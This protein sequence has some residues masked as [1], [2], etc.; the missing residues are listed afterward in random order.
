MAQE[1]YYILLKNKRP[2]NVGPVQQSPKHFGDAVLS[3]KYRVAHLFIDGFCN[4]AAFHDKSI[5]SWVCHESDGIFLHGTFPIFARC[6]ISIRFLN[7]IASI[8]QCCYLLGMAA[9]V[10]REHLHE[11]PVGYVL[12]ELLKHL[13]LLTKAVHKDVNNIFMVFFGFKIRHGQTNQ[14]FRIQ[15]LS[16][17]AIFKIRNN[18]IREMIA[19]NKLKA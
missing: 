18:L 16:S 3:S 17:F 12:T 6:L 9:F 7:I 10:K 15:S 14:I 19:D 1:W 5:N 8:S 2:T 4:P 13:L 11:F